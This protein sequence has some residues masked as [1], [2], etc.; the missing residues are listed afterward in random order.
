MNLAVADLVG[1]VERAL[2]HGGALLTA[3]ERRIVDRIVALEGEA[4]VAYAR[5]TARVSSVFEVDRLTIAGV[6]DVSSALA[7]LERVGLVDGLVG[8]DARARALLKADLVVALRRLGLPHRGDREELLA[9]LRGQRGFSRARFVRVRH[10]PLVRRLERWAFLE[11]FPDRAKPV[12]ERLGVARWPTYALT[13]GAVLPPSRRRWLA[14]EQLADRLSGQG[15][16]LTPQAALDA[17]RDGTARVP[18]RL[19]LTQLLHHELLA[20]GH[21]LERQ[22]RPAEACELYERLVDEGGL[23]LPKV[24]FR[25][26]QALVADG[27][28]ADALDLLAR[29]RVE[30]SGAERM[31]IVRGMRRIA[32]TLGRGIAPDPPLRPAPRREIRLER[33]DTEGA[34]PRWGSAEQTVEAAVCHWLG[35]SGR[36]A[37]HGEGRPFSTLFSL[38]F[39]DVLFMPVP[40]ALPVRYLTRPLDFGT[41]AFRAARADAIDHVWDRVRRGGASAL[42]RDAWDRLYGVRIVGARWDQVT[43]PEL[44]TLADSLGHDGLHA[45]LEPML[46]HGSRHHA[47][48]PDLVIWPGP[49]V[50]L[51]ESFPS[52]LDEGLCLAEIK[53]PGDRLRDEQRIWLDRLIGAGVRAEL[54]EVVPPPAR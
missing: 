26:G 37:R 38:L 10:R 4:A 36:G 8:W 3:G 28:A 9:N 53:S 5:L 21:G 12:M 40:G 50:R 18:A 29:A 16:P 34:R 22:R 51:G 44:Q 19:D 27:R 1:V 48:L 47:G 7:E 54:W 17:L 11:P 41:P 39:A 43:L 20:V 24:A 23:R 2:C 46:A 52:R 42:I 32:R 31:A 15:P 35:E 13:S 30:A 6:T 49:A 14:Y 45:I 33:L 25:W